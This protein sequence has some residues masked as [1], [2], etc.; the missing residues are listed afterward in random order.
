MLFL[1]CYVWT[2]STYSWKVYDLARKFKQIL[3]KKI[4]T[5]YYEVS[6]IALNQTKGGIL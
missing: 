3:P 4:Y 2:S 6:Y 5:V 1:I